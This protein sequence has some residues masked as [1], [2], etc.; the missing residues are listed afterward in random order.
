M[1]S[2]RWPNYGS[3]TLVTIGENTHAHTHTHIHIHTHRQKPKLWLSGDSRWMRTNTHAATLSLRSPS[4]LR[5]PPA[6]AMAR[7]SAGCTMRGQKKRLSLPLT[8]PSL[9]M[10][11]CVS[12]RLKNLPF[13]FTKLKDLAALWLSDNQVSAHKNRYQVSAF[14]VSYRRYFRRHKLH[15]FKT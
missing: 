11:V 6:V 9:C 3:S 13:T 15:W 1:R 12:F 14:S 4:S 7:C 8:S 2:D 5:P 10:C